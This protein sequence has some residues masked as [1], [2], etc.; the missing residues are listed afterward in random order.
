MIAVTA[1]GLVGSL[2]T[3]FLLSFFGINPIVS[4]SAN[5]QML[6][7]NAF[8]V[9][10]LYLLPDVEIAQSGDLEKGVVA[11]GEEDAVSR[12]PVG[13]PVDAPTHTSPSIESVRE[14]EVRDETA[15]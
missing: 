15:S 5:R 8:A 7:P 4:K 9:G 1:I 14:T 11:P 6:T 2:V 3:L 12:E 10:G 13:V